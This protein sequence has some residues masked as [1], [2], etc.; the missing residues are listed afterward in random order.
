VSQF[1]FV[2]RYSIYNLDL[3]V[4]DANGLVTDADS[5]P[6]A[7]MRHYANDT[8]VFT[9]STVKI[10]TGVYRL[11]LSSVE[12]S[13]AGLYY[14]LWTYNLSAIPQEYRSDIEIPTTLSSQFE[15]LSDGYRAIVE[16]TWDRFEDL[17]D[18]AVGGPHLR[19]YTQ[20]NFGRE[21]LAGLLRIAIGKLNTASQPHQS[22]S[23][24]DNNFP[25]ASWGALL[26]QA[27]YV[28][29]VRHLMRSYVEQPD[30][31]GINVARLDRTSYYQ[32][33]QSILSVEQS[34]LDGMLDHF[35]IASMNLG[36]AGVLV[37]GGAYGNFT[38]TVPPG[39]P[40]HRPPFGSW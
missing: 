9:R 25:F 37:A 11:V 3:T 32:R 8:V 31:Q 30:P 28:E 2:G 29:T 33:W 13:D 22:Y 35:K 27:L 24:E 18:S 21:R 16:Q 36:R 20:S 5:L 40:R 14:V 1:Q 10:A 19:E 17:F 34:A 6:S 4:V 7:S 23:I 15:A 38:R 12:T 39:R 26:E